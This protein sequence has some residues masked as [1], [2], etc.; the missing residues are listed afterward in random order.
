MTQMV[1]KDIV[2]NRSRLDSST[3]ARVLAMSVKENGLLW[4]GLIGL[5][6]I[7]SALAEV[8]FAKAA[9]LRA[10]RNL[11]GMNSIA[12]NKVIWENWDW[13]ATGEEWSPSPEWKRSVID[14]LM[15][16]NIAPGS[17]VVEIG[18]GGG[19]WT[20]ELQT[21]AAMLTGIDISEACVRACR[22]RFA[23]FDN[24]EFRLG[25]GMDLDG[26]EKGSVD[27]IWSFDVFVHVNRPQF[28]AYAAE[29]ARVLKPG[30][31]GII[32]HGRVGGAHGGWRSDVTAISVQDCLR[33]AGLDVSAQISS[34][35]HSGRE[36]K[37]GLYD[38]AVTIFKK[39]I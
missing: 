5:Y 31:V 39:P 17:I 10:H 28:Q 8:A 18:P 2:E 21:R 12:I 19:R 22:R 32:Q 33:S 30:G 6:Y 4:T 36:F 13:S 7:A 29:F 11:P 23:E 20:G 9:K 14:V 34:W 38:D 27:A 24:V 35:W 15:N 1:M 16:P 25:S 37:A 26:V 3:K